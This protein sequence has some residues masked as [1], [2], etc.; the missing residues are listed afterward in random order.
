MPCRKIRTD[1]GVLFL[2]NNS[3]DQILNIAKQKQRSLYCERCSDLL[4]ILILY[5]L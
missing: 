4:I 1:C 3:Y 2:K 5:L